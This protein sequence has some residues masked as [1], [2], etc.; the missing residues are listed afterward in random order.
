MHTILL[1]SSIHTIP[2]KTFKWC[3]S[4]RA[5]DTG[6]EH[7]L[8]PQVIPKSTNSNVWCEGGML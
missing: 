4:R 1:I 2:A 7:V 8:A 5:A 6:C 3:P